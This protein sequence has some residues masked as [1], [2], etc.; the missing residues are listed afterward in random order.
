MV[1]A[2]VKEA[3]KHLDYEKA[4]KKA[5]EE[6]LKKMETIMEICH[7]WDCMV[8]EDEYALKLIRKQTEMKSGK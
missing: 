1:E 4:G 2:M 6:I 8:I 3:Q 5:S 7:R